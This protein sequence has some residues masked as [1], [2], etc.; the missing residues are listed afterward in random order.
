MKAPCSKCVRETTHHILFKCR[1]DDNEYIV[2]SCGGCEAVSMR[3]QDLHFTDQI[4]YYPSPVSR[5]MPG[6]LQYMR[7]GLDA[8][9]EKIADLMNE[10][11]E[12]IYGGQYRLAAMGIRA[13]LEQVMI[14]KVGDNR[15]FDNNL[16][17]FQSEG[18]ISAV[19]RE[20][21][22]A[23][24]DFGHAAIHRGF[25]PSEKDLTVALD[26]VEGVLAP[27]FGHPDEAKGLRRRVPPRK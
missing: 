19:Q 5:Q 7:L 6:W 25:V 4:K 26:I 16:N 1:E 10:V 20:S 8:D 2:M 23:T 21:M 11:Y 18:Y 24:L 17:A 9:E 27:I 15:T 3:V 14:M 13:A 22:H 12:V